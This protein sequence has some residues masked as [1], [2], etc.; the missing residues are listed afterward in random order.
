MVEHSAI[1]PFDRTIARLADAGKE[2]DHLAMINLLSDD[3]IIRSPITELIRF[4]GIEQASDL[5]TR[6]FLYISDI[7][8]YKVIGTGANEQVI[9]WRGRIGRVY[10]E[11]ANLLKLNDQ[12]QICEMTVFM[13][14]VPGL[15]ALA[16]QLAPSL[17][18]KHGRLRWLFVAVQLKLISLIYRSAEPMVIKAAKAGVPVPRGS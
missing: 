7:R 6:V 1:C 13:R 17:A 3:I 2:H 4:E 15:L 8:F 16:A 9:F 14:A 18:R 10:L 5:F 11:E 12:G